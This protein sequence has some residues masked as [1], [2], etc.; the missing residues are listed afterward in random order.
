MRQ[1]SQAIIKQRRARQ[2]GVTLLEIMVVVVIVGILAVI[3]IPSYRQYSIRAQR[4]EAKSALLQLAT[5]QERFYL[6]N[7]T[8]TNN[9]AAL[10]FAGGISENGVYTLAIPLANA[11]TYQ[12]TAVPTPGGGVNGKDQSTDGECQQF[13]VNS[14]GLKTA[15][16]DPNTACW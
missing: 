12:A 3:A 11:I 16:P 15:A 5:N 7:N 14:Q 9:L 8:Y 10:G 4:T 13:G 2:R 1:D 6:Q